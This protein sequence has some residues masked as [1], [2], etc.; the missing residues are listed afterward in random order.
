MLN[1]EKITVESLRKVCKDKGYN[2][3]E[4]GSYN[5]N[6]IGIRSNERVSNSFDDILSVSYLVNGVWKLH[7]FTITTDPG[8]WELQK[9]SFVNAQEYGT[10]IMACGQYT[11]SYAYGYHGTGTWRHKALIQV[12]PINIYRDKNRDAILDINGPTERG[13]FGINIHASSLTVNQ[14][15]VCNWSAG[16]QVFGIPKEY[17]EFISIIEQAV[18]LYGPKFT[19]T[20]INESD[21]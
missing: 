15:L 14:P 3:F 12:G 13:L 2:F 17:Y 10:A 9:P 8:L 6:L 7:K 4:K 21:L 1:T 11:G 5:L 19:Y 20:L 18:K 16:C